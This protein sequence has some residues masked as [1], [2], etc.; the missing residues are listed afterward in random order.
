MLFEI[1]PILLLGFGLGLV[2]ALDADHIMAVSVLCNRRAGVPETILCSSSWALGHGSA[3]CASGLLLFAFG[4][5]IPESVQL[6]AD[7]SVGVL[8][9]LMGVFCIFRFR[10][11]SISLYQHRHG[12]IVHTHWQ[13]AKHNSYESNRSILVGM[14]HGLA[15]S[16][17]ILALIP[18]TGKGDFRPALVY[19][20]VFMLGVLLSMLIFGV[21]FGY[22]QNKLLDRNKRLF[23]W[24]R[25]FISVA[26]ITVGG[27]WLTRLP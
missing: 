12:N 5:S 21:S 16:A 24:S 17:P 3:L 7:A 1:S 23:A 26:S 25:Y 15:G 18:V 8:L 11:D 22:I 13:N 20:L 4:W 10:K 14:L 6:L 9:I 2:H 19:L 27:L